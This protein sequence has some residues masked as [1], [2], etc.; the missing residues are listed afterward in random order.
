MHKPTTTHW[1]VV[2][3][4][5]YYLKVTPNHGIIYRPNSFHLTAYAD[6]DYAGDP[7]DRRS[8]SGYCIFLG[9]NLIF[10]SLKKQR[11]VSCLSTEVEYR[12]LSYTA[13]ALSW[14]RTLFR[15]LHLP[16]ASPQ[17]CLFHEPA[18]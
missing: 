11:G 16:L 17:L 5:L 15:E 14:Y 9:D 13:T 6:A 4:I 7:D 2:K 1:V 10:W 12:Q 3:R 8:T 18:S